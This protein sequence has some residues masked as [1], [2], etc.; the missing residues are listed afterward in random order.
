MQR[1]V[2][3]KKQIRLVLIADSRTDFRLLFQYVWVGEDEN[4][5]EGSL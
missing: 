5:M 3:A 2:A 1:I 4:G